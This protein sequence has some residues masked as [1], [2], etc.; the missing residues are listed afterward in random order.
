MSAGVS[1]STVG[2]PDT[3][4]RALDALVVAALA[5]GDE[6]HLRVLGYGEISLVLG[7][8]VDEPAFAC[9]LLPVFDGGA[10]FD[11]YRS[12][13]GEYLEALRAAGLNPVS[14]ELRGVDRPDG[15]IAG[16]AVQPV[17]PSSGLAP[18]VLTGADPEH[19]HSVVRAVV[20]SAAAAVSPRVG[21]DAQLSNWWWDGAGLTY[22]DVTTPM[23]WSSDGE[24]QLDVDL[25][26]RPLPWLLRG[27]V[28]RFLVPRILD[29]YRD[30]RGVYLDLCGNLIK[31]HL[32][33]WLPRFVSAANEHLDQALSTDE[34]RRYYRSDAR[35]WSA[36]LAVRQ[37]D[38]A[39]QMRV[40]RRPYPFLL[41]KRIER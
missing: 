5:S 4:L 26:V 14:T 13:L 19:G 29:A 18:A 27:A 17:L 22:I 11:A 1:A 12:T 35:L 40:R 37:L 7:W 30:L 32:D 20:D 24:P 41:P 28:K 3:E 2:I 38:R 10:R 36:L 15:S 8:P 34:V 33:G 39:W 23:L 25:L 21:I 6:S 9:K 16:Y 31:E